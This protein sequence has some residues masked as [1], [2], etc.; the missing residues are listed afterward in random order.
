MKI[1]LF[2]SFLFCSAAYAGDWSRLVA[3]RA[4]IEHVYY[5]HRLGDKPGFEKALPREALEKLVRLDIRKESVLKAYMAWKSRPRWWRQNCNVLTPPRARRRFS[6]NSRP[7]LT[8]MRGDL[9]RPWRGPWWW[10]GNC[11][12]ILTM[13]TSSTL[14][15]D[16]R[17]SKCAR[18]YSPSAV[19]VWRSKWHCLKSK[20]PKEAQDTIWQFTSRPTES[21]AVATNQVEIQKRFGP[22][23]RILSS[24]VPGDKE[25][26]FYFED[27]PAELQRVLRAQLRQ[28]GDV[29]AVIET[30]GGFLL[31]V[32]KEK[33]DTA[34]SVTGLTLAKRNY[35]QWLEGF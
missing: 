16:G 30:P 17:S 10:I 35:E 20:H 2:I 26:K 23:A 34:L 24:P 22:D 14:R 11:A 12:A 7:P 32:A 18:N 13:T 9:R 3:D 4:A 5:D 21:V 33:T 29:S 27:L 19:K 15:N 31:Y 28:A 1:W 25:A 6:P 8:T